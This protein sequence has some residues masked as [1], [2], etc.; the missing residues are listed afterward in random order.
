MRFKGDGEKRREEEREER[1]GGQKQQKKKRKFGSYFIFIFYL[2]LLEQWE[3]Q[4]EEREGERGNSAFQVTRVRIKERWRR[5]GRGGEVL[6]EERNWGGGGD[7]WI[8]SVEAGGPEHFAV[9]LTDKYHL[10]SFWL[11][12]WIGGFGEFWN[13]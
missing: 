10:S 11:D 6:L 13:S 5:R 12:G 2:Y 1:S 8:L 3:S 4:R 7:S 9:S